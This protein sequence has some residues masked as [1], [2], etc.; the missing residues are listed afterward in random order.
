MDFLIFTIKKH[1]NS[2]KQNFPVQVSL[3]KSNQAYET[4]N[5]DNT[6]IIAIRAGSPC[7]K[8]IFL[9]TVTEP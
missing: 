1:P 9:E 3:L 5:G 2:P 8:N 7:N 6:A 4:I